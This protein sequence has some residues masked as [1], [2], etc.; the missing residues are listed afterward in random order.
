MHADEARVL[1]GFPPDTRPTLDQVKAAYKRKVWE[2]HPDRFPVHQKPHAECKFKLVQDEK[3][4]VQLCIP[5]LNEL[6]FQG[7][8]EEEEIML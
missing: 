3:F 4:Q 1:L 8:G 6:E 2:T 7:H 5:K